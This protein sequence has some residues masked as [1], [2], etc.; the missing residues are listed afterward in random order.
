MYQFFF[1]CFLVGVMLT[2]IFFLVGHLFEF[3]GGDGL[4]FD[5]HFLGVELFL[6]FSPSLVMM[7]LTVFGGC[8]VLLMK[9][10]HPLS[11]ILI[12]LLSSLI[13]LFIVFLVYRYIL[14]PL[15]KAQNTSTPESDDLVGLIA[16]VT[17]SIFQDS[18][19]EIS[20]VINSNSYHAPAKSTNK[21]EIK[22]GSR[23]VI[24]WIKDHVFY[25]SSIDI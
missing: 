20:Y 11:S 13:A 18:Y 7:F 2:V 22:A 17:E 1:V 12:L 5:I 6:P 4:N 21:G 16:V 10:K 9:M 14:K 23:V 24:C 15:K 19:G 8:G 3:L 25:V